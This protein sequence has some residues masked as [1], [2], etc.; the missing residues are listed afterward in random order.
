MALDNT[1]T[2][3]IGRIRAGDEQAAA[4][5]VRRFEPVIRM[6]VRMGMR[7]PNLNRLFDSMDICQSVLG[8]FFVR[9]ASGQYDLDQPEHL[10]QLLVQMARN[11]LASQAR[12]HYRERRDIRRISNDS[13][14]KLEAVADGPSPS[15]VVAGR[16]LLEKFREKLTAEERQLVHWRNQGRSWSEIAEEMGGSPNGRCQQ[17]SRA[18][19]R[20]AHELKLDV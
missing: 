2:E 8:S 12:L 5:L 14:D 10:I 19:D 20:V 13:G 6:E 1:F 9:A 11:K 16:E 15:Q 18:V 7:D 17:L 4:E 3:F